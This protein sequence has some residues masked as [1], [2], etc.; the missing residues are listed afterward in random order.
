MF[1]PLMP[2]AT[3]VWLIENTTLSFVQIAEFCGIHPLEIQGIADGE[4]A[5]GIV[6]QDPV[7]FSILTKEEIV[8][9]EADKSRR[10]A[11]IQADVPQSVARAKGPRYTP[12]AKRQDRPNAIAWLL[13]YH[14]ELTD[15][16]VEKLV[17]TTKSTISSIRERSHWN[18]TNIKLEDPV[19][20]GMCTQTELDGAVTKA[21]RRKN[22]KDK[23][24]AEVVAQRQADAEAEAQATQAAARAAAAAAQTGQAAS[25]PTDPA[26]S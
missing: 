22:V 17:G 6:G 23:R 1:R 26:T 19:S 11:I 25:S 21:M 10:L 5:N 16:Q 9:C 13:R 12:V 8:A 14:P 18:M 7:T 24:E 3:A 20:L 4:V 15:G 2:K